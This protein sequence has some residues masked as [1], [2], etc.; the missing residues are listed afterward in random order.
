MV[1]RHQIRFEAGSTDWLGRSNGE[2]SCRRWVNQGAV[3]DDFDG[4]AAVRFGRSGGGSRQCNAARQG[5]RQKSLGKGTCCGERVGINGDDPRC[6][7]GTPLDWEDWNETGADR[8]GDS[9]DGT[10]LHAN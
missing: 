9:W 8:G 3:G 5:V 4:P 1:S 2:L 6:Q 10:L 7:V